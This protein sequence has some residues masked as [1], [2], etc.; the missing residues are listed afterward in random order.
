MRQLGLA[1]VSSFVML[2]GACGGSSCP[3]DVP[4]SIDHTLDA[5]EADRLAVEL[6][7]SSIENECEA[8]C[9]QI[10]DENMAP[11]GSTFT[12]MQV[13]ECTLEMPSTDAS[14]DPVSGYL[15]CSGSGER[16]SA[17]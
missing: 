4:F 3:E 16:C 8:A 15:R 12:V 1:L 2:V 7:V 11:D 14:G 10:S 17:D 6:G 5:A 9:T 13:E